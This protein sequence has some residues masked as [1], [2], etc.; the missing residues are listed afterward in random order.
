MIE[1][2]IGVLLT[3]LSYYFACLE[4]ISAKQKLIFIVLFVVFSSF[5]RFFINVDLNNDYQL[6]FNFDI[7]HKP[8]SFLSF[9]L[10]EPYL[11]SIYTFFTFFIESKKDV[12]LAMYFFNFFVNTLFFI[13]IL[14]RNDIDMWKKMLLFVLHYFLFGFVLLRNGPAYI[15]FAL[16]FY[17]SFRGKKFIWVLITPFM[18][19]SSSLMLVSYFHKW[20]HYFKVLILVPIVLFL[21]FLV[22]RNY[23]SSFAAFDSILSKIDVYSQGIPEVGVMHI[24]FFLF[25]F[26]LVSMGFLFYKYKMLHPILIT[27]L[28]FYTI[29]FFI[30]PI[31]AHRFSPYVF[32]ALLLF[33]FDKIKNEKMVLLVNKLT[34]VLFPIFVYSLFNA[35]RTESFRDI[36]IR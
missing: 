10:N 21:L 20:R 14:Y 28:L 34:I 7:F 29:T 23:L 17:Y 9:L 1:I 5:L 2:L 22:M 13:W 3:F 35:H 6:Y 26:I 32:F 33:P 25:I 4:S 27:T 8:I 15:L 11:Y 31:V 24:L 18:H 12:F 30:N 36:F 16:Y 19:I